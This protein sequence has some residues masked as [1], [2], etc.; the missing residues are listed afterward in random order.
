M[1]FAAP[2]FLYGLIGVSIPIIIHLVELRKARKIFFTNVAFIKEIKNITSN[3]RQI[4]QILILLSR[5]LFLIFLVL[6]FAQPFIPAEKKIVQGS[7]RLKIFLDNSFS[8][9]NESSSTNANLLETAASNIKKIVGS[10]G[11]NG[12]YSYIDHSELYSSY[13]DYSAPKLADVV[14]Q[15][16]FTNANKSLAA[17]LND[18]STGSTLPYTG[19]IYSDF[20]KST[21]NSKSILSID[22]RNQYY[23]IKVKG[24]A[25]ANAFVDSVYVEDEFIRVNQLNQIKVKVRNSGNQTID[26]CNVKFYIGADQV[27]ALSIK[28]PAKRSTTFTLNYR[29]NDTKAKA[30]RIELQDYPLDFDN[31]YFFTLQAATAIN[32]VDISSYDNTATQR[33]FTNEPVFKYRQVSPAQF[34]YTLLKETN[35]LILNSLEQVS[36]ALA[37]NLVN[38]VNEGGGLIFVPGL[39]ATAQNSER[40]LQQLNINH[41]Q[42]SGNATATAPPQYDMALPDRN[43]P[44]FKNIF[45]KASPQMVMPKAAQL[46]TWSRASVDI[47]KFRDNNKYLSQFNR[48]KGRV[49]LFAAPLTEPFSSFINNALFVP[50]MYKIA[51]QSYQNKVNMAYTL[52]DKNIVYRAADQINKEIFK[53]VKDSIAYIPEQQIREGNLVFSVPS[54]VN[55]AGFYTLTKGDKPEAVF[56]FNLPKSESELNFYSTEELK[57]LTQDTQNVHVLDVDDELSIKNL[58]DQENR[59]TQLWKYCLILCLLFA[60]LE[61]LLIRFM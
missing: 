55:E 46:L 4:K 14:D 59:G 26:A 43:N 54:D 1:N 21:I 20:Q 33:L 51:M 35:L 30:C 57:T 47:L 7:D 32:I 52:S 9:Q 22:K 28:V 40:L 38:F 42:A 8:M 19:L 39:A 50:V 16:K 44:F 58:F 27:S 29:L 13:T 3:H 15:I 49:Y 11:M 61:V 41:K 10:M 45:A 60:L 24:T 12:R 34:N 2:F 48:G 23:L 18:F 56:A 31:K 25:N 36:P 53:L 6:L 5:I 37:G 17:I